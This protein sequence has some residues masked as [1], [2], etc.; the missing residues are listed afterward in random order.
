MEALRIVFAGTPE[1]ALPAL[2]ALAESGPRLTGPPDAGA[3]CAP[4]PSSS[5]RWP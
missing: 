5:A 3:S 4:A 1:F 2:D